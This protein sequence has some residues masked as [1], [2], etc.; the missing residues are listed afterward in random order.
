MIDGALE[1]IDA[2]RVVMVPGG[3]AEPVVIERGIVQSIS[4]RGAG[5]VGTYVG[6]A[7]LAGWQQTPDASWTEEA[8][9]IAATRRGSAV[10]RDVGAPSRAR[11]D[12]VVSWR[13]MTASVEA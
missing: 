10:S 12:I 8:G 4:R 1:S 11:Y 2:T 9:R 5:V 6:P 13:R 3:K 7:G